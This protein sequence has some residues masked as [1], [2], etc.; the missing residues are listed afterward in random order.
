MTSTVM[1]DK[2]QYGP[3]GKTL[4]AITIISI[5]V[6]ISMIAIPLWLNSDT[7]EQT[8]A[9]AAEIRTRLSAVIN[10]QNANNNLNN[11]AALIKR[12]AAQKTLNDKVLEEYMPSKKY[13]IIKLENNHYQDEDKEC[14]ICLM[15]FVDEDECRI[16]ICNHIFHS[17]C[18]KDWLC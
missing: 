1:Y 15:D 7:S 11:L 2:G 17:S 16:T 4:F 18:V 3:E 12:R 9:Q 6:V 14:C 13:L 10:N 8:R 5:I